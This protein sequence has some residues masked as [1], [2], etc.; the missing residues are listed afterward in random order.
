M[1]NFD[2]SF[3]E[4]EVRSGFYIPSMTKRAWAVEM[5]VLSEIDRICQKYDIAYF[6]DWGTLLGAIRH[7]GFIPWDD[8]MDICMHRNDYERFLSVAQEELPPDYHISSFETSENNWNFLVNVTSHSRMCFEPEY[9]EKY[10]GFPYMAGLDIFFLDNIPEDARLREDWITIIKYIINVADLMETGK[11]TGQELE[12]SLSQIENICQVKL[13]RNEDMYQRKLQLYKLA[14]RECARYNRTK[15]PE[16]TQLM[17]LGLYHNW[18]LPA[19]YYESSIRVPFE[20]MDIP[21]PVAYEKLLPMK[22]PD[23]MTIRMGGSAHN[24]PYYITQKK[25]LGTDLDFVPKYVFSVDHLKKDRSIAGDSLK[26]IT[27]NFLSSLQE[28]TARLD[29]SQP[30]ATQ[31]L[32][33]TMQAQMIELGTLIEQTKGNGHSVVTLIEQCCEALYIFHETLSDENADSLLQMISELSNK[34]TSDILDRKE[35]VFLPFKATYWKCFEAEWLEAVHDPSCDVS[36]IPIPYYY[37]KYDGTFLDMHYE[38]AD[39]PAEVKITPYD[40]FDFSLH[41]PDKIY[42][43]NPYDEYNMTL[44]VHPNFYASNIKNY[45]DTLIYKPFFELADFSADNEI[46]KYN[47]QFYCTMPGVVQADQVILQSEQIRQ[48]YIEQLTEFAGENTQEIWTKKI[49]EA[50]A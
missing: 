29:I 42:I 28:N 34:L 26:T 23:Y 46:C 7:H 11:L 4:D 13:L 14:K 21:V 19:S 20:H 38:G 35:I 2:P 15:T 48:R 25:A 12:Y 49:I 33:V 16:I 37:K 1:L 44:S 24:Y 9:L 10:H 32:L 31:E 17:P 18:I 27:R 39:F 50:Q 47:M 5:E 36:V 3:F 30:D 22:Y 43:Q 45:T 41:Q 40:T 8:D 6:A